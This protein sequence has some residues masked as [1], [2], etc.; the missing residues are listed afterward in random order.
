M[1]DIPL[2][3]FFKELEVIN[4]SKK[5][6]YNE[7]DS[8]IIW[9]TD[10]T[11]SFKK[12]ER[13]LMRMYPGIADV[14]INWHIDVQDDA[15]RFVGGVYDITAPLH[16]TEETHFQQ[17]LLHDISNIPLEFFNRC[18]EVYKKVVYKFNNEV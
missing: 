14:K 4:E 11:I 18:E 7:L 1:M 3:Y 16:L 9:I 8:C 17:S 12:S 10:D 5:I 2:D 13:V 15:I 6:L